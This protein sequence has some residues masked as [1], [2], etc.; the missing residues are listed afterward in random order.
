MIK[1]TLIVTENAL[2]EVHGQLN[3]HKD[4][5]ENKKKSTLTYVLVRI[6]RTNE[7]IQRAS[8]VTPSVL[9]KKSSKPVVVMK[10]KR[11]RLA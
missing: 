10:R 7:S 6:I 1:R 11:L 8:I 3:K 2:P 5:L 4:I 9:K